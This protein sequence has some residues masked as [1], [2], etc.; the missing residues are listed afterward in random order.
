M[1]NQYGNNVAVNLQNPEHGWSEPEEVIPAQTKSGQHRYHENTRLAGDSKIYVY[2]PM[3][4]L[5]VT[6]KSQLIK[7][8]IYLHTV[9]KKPCI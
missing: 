8:N 1:I 7:R 6:M 3:M 4:C 5:I 9:L 2:T